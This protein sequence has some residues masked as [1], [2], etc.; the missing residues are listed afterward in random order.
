MVIEY[1]L[2]AVFVM[3]VVL[4][5]I[6]FYTDDDFKYMTFDD[7]GMLLII[8]GLAGAIWPAT[9]AMAILSGLGYLM[10][11]AAAYVAKFIKGMLYNE[12]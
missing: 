10:F 1:I 3:F 7:K 8:A 11:N 5:I 9:L 4:T 2:V 6:A 12:G